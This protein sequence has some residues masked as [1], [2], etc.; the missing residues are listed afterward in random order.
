MHPPI[1]V[2][3]PFGVEILTRGI[4]PR[5]TIPANGL[6]LARPA[7]S[8]AVRAKVN[9]RVGWVSGIAS[10]RA[11]RSIALPNEQCPVFASVVGPEGFEPPTKR[12]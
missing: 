8:T 10:N 12:L 9:R 5:T 4:C 7:R 1:V 3:F 2:Q 6:H 11:A